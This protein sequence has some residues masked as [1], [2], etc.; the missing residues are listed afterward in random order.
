[1]RHFVLIVGLV[2]LLATGCGSHRAHA[3]SQ[4]PPPPLPRQQYPN[5][6]NTKQIGT[7]QNPTPNFKW[8]NLLLL[9]LNPAAT[10]PLPALACLL[11]LD[12]L[13][14]NF[15]IDANSILLSA[16]LSVPLLAITL[17]PIEKL[18]GF[19]PLK[20]VT[21]ASKT[22]S[23]YAFGKTLAPLRTFVAATLLATSA[24]VF[25]VRI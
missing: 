6:S 3:L 16:K 22:I 15:I 25:E 4:T 9:A 24:A 20:E 1:M 11:K 19:H 14:T 13:G 7:K 5:Q 12:P 21:K 2:V 18:P 17:L 23:L 10:A 8:K